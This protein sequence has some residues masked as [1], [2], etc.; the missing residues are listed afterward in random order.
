MNRM[1]EKSISLSLVITMF[2]LPCIIM[3]SFIFIVDCYRSQNECVSSENP[4]LR[5]VVKVQMFISSSSCSESFSLK[6]QSLS[7]QGSINFFVPFK[8][9][10]FSGPT[11]IFQTF[12]RTFTPLSSSFEMSA[13][14]ILPCTASTMQDAS[15]EIAFLVLFRACQAHPATSRSMI[16]FSKFMSSKC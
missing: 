14:C 7:C 5:I 8:R 13:G 16:P 12:F 2:A 10:I 1:R 3:I 4:E 15:S 6:L 11:W 9:S